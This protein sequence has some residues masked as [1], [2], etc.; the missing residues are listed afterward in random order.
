MT[1][2]D[3]IREHREING[4]SMDAFSEKSGVSKAYI[5]M[6]EKDFNPK[7]KKSI[8]PSI[9]LIKQVADAIGK[10]FNVVFNSLDGNV[11]LLEESEI[12]DT[13]QSEVDSRNPFSSFSPSEH[14]IKVF[15]AYHNQPNMQLAVDR[16]LGVENEAPPKKVHQNEYTT[17]QIAAYGGDGVETIR[18]TAEADKAVEA[19][20]SRRLAEER[21]KRNK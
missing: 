19:I 16:L 12:T 5:S 18:T 11:S 7:S 15:T 3:I 8:A 2:G 17:I 6:L 4:L 9:K 1:L 14:E 13:N 21:A 10:D 20:V